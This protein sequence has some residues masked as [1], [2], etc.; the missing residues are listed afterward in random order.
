MADRR[1]R[2]AE[3]TIALVSRLQ[4]SQPSL[5]VACGTNQTCQPSPNRAWRS[6]L[7][8]V[9]CVQLAAHYPSFVAAEAI[10]PSEPQAALLIEDGLALTR[11]GANEPFSAT[12]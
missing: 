12:P 5:P 6:A 7:A 1:Q 3:A 11:A 2:R 4:G 9:H 10:W 8:L